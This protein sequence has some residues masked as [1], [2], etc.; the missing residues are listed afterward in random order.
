MRR[1]RTGAQFA[2][3]ILL[4]ADSRRRKQ[5]GARALVELDVLLISVR[6]VLDEILEQVRSAGVE[7]DWR[8][9]CEGEAAGGRCQ[10]ARLANVCSPLALT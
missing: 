4:G 9:G 10:E 2:R 6:P 7:I 3:A 5:I 1:R 8:P